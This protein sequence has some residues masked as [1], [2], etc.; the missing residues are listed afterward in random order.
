MAFDFLLSSDFM[1]PDP[2]ATIRT[3]VSALGLREPK[4][5]WRQAFPTHSYIAWFARVHPSFAVAPT[6]LEPQG[7]LHVDDPG[8]PFFPDFLAG[9][10]KFQGLHRAHKTHAVVLVT[11]EAEELQEK[12]LRRRV[13]FRLAPV[14]PE[15]PWDRYWIGVTPDQINYDPSYDGGLCIEVLPLAPVQLPDT[16]F[17][18]PPPE[19][20]NPAPGEMVRLVSRGQLVHDLDEVLCQLSRNLDWEP[21]GPVENVPEEGYRRARMSFRLAQS[22]T[23]EIIQPTSAT[24]PAG[25]FLSTWGPGPYH[26]RIAVSDLNAK[27]DDLKERGTRFTDMAPSSAVAGER[28]L[29]DPAQVQGLRFEFVEY[30]PLS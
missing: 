25:R 8:D 6:S 15:M 28:I 17:Q 3:F 14:T 18:V 23:V 20:T 16:A 22:A 5:T 4:P 24:S 9:L 21:V 12:L 13:P 10:G 30:E 1:V 2:D 11:S 26:T 29:V 27:R 7:H 19:P